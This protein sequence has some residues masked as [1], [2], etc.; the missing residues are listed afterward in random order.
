MS[1][2]E[3][4]RPVLVNI[5]CGEVC[6][7]DWV[8]LDVSPS[9]PGVIPY[10]LRKGLPFPDGD[11]DACYSA[12]VLEHMDPEEAGRFLRECHRVTR[13]G[14]VVRIVVP[15][16]EDIARAYLDALRRTQA[17]DPA[18]EADYDWMMLELYDQTVRT[19]RG[20]RMGRGLS[21]PD[22]PNRAFV[23]DRV[24]KEADAYWNP[25]STRP[26]VWRRLRMK[27]PGWLLDRA[28][29]GAARVLVYAVAGRRGHAAFREGIFRSGGEIHCW[30][31]D[32]FSLGR[33]LSRAGYL[34][35]R[36]EGAAKSRIPGFEGYGLDVVD[37]RERRPHSLFMEGTRP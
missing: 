8:N 37:G 4:G 24:G 15:D 1:V 21:D 33:L 11:C 19:E 27:G 10:D 3:T 18:A 34:D 32:R 29:T 28:R 2:P 17:G 26:S 22:L 23:K 16:L 35:V 13:P 31:Y 5:G 36:V 14:G 7:P 6:H 9:H 20:G 12:H 30:M 25:P